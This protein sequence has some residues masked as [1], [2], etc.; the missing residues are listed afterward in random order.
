MF[1]Y[2]LPLTPNPLPKGEEDKVAY[3]K[4]TQK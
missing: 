3:E 4:N 1:V 2:K